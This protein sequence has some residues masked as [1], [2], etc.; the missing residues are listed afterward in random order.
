MNDYFAR[1]RR[2][3]LLKRNRAAT[4]NSSVD[5][6]S[7]NSFG[8]ASSLSG[9]S[10][11]RRRG[12]SS[13]H[14]SSNGCPH[15]KNVRFEEG[16]ALTAAE[17][18]EYEGIP[19]ECRKDCYYTGD[20]LMEIRRKEVKSI[21]EGL[22]RLAALGRTDR[23][24][25]T[26]PV[27]S[28]VS[29]G[30]QPPESEEGGGEDMPPPQPPANAQ[31]EED[32]EA[33]AAESTRRMELTW[34][35][36]EDYR[37]GK[38]KN[39]HAKL[40]TMVV[41]REWREQTLSGVC[42]WDMLRQVSKASSRDDRRTADD[43]ADRDAA[44]QGYTKPPHRGLKRRVS[45]EWTAMTSRILQLQV[46]GLPSRLSYPTSSSPTSYSSKTN[47]ASAAAAAATA[48]ASR[49]TTPSAEQVAR[50]RMMANAA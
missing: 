45:R 21:K 3:F 48:A 20:E 26:I 27:A 42:D 11:S 1:P 34:R 43:L 18:F 39:E 32:D 46:K 36:I 29:G 25:E 5:G 40:H 37:D 7:S 35:G 33:A 19:D 2:S 22:K 14:G 9:S 31:E 15:S 8:I 17:A 41:L 6:S 16:S 50:M 4:N 28:A 44:E 12:S 24:I 47:K 13:S 38:N 30:K 49:T 10:S 23:D